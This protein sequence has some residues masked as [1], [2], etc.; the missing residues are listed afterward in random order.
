MFWRGKECLK[1][2]TEGLMLNI[3]SV[4]ALQVICELG[5]KEKLRWMK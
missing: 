5:E 3:V 1:T 4:Y 2:E